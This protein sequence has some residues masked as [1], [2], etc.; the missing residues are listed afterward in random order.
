MPIIPIYHERLFPDYPLYEHELVS[1]LT[2]LAPEGNTIKKAYISNAKT[3][4]IREGDILMFYRSH[5]RK[6]ITSLGI[7]E[8]TLRTNDPAEIASIV[9]NRTVYTLEEIKQLALKN[10]LVLIFRHQKYFNIPISMRNLEKRYSIWGPIQSIREISN[11][12]Y[13]GIIGDLQ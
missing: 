12:S 3:K 8:K 13:S 10:A 11:K 4:R 6:E 7:V 2:Q 1:D 5:D 9:S